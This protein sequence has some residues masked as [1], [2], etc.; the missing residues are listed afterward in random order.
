ME[1]YV[2]SQVFSEKIGN[3]QF[4]EKADITSVSTGQPVNANT[5]ILE[6]ET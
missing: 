5:S 3:H 1:P 2:T 4:L 6:L